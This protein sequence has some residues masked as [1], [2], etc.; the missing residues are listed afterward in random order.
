MKASAIPTKRNPSNRLSMLGR[1]RPGV[2]AAS[3]E[4]LP[5]DTWKTFKSFSLELL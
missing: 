3:K 5:G 2:V 1:N 4:T